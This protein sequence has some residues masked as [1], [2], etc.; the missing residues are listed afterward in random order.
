MA[1][2]VCQ[3][4]FRLTDSRLAACARSAHDPP[5][6]LVDQSTMHPGGCSGEARANASRVLREVH[7][8]NDQAA[9]AKPFR[10]L[11]GSGIWKSAAKPK[12]RP[13]GHDRDPTVPDRSSKRR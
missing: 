9:A 13:S 10:A 2:D 6:G 12:P 3:S 4:C 8:L 5:A 7:P 1:E 11:S